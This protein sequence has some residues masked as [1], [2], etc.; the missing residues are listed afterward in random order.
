[1]A[2]KRLTDPGFLDGSFKSRSFLDALSSSSSNANFPDLKPSSFRGLPSLWISEEEI[3]AL[4]TP[5]QFLLVG[6]FFPSRRPSL[7]VI[8]R[9]F[10]NLKLIGNISVTLLDTSHDLIKLINNLDYSRIFYHISYLDLDNGQLIHRAIPSLPHSPPTNEGVDNVEFCGDTNKL[11]SI[12]P[13]GDPVD[14]EAKAADLSLTI[15]D[16]TK[17]DANL[18]AS[19]CVEAVTDVGDKS[20]SLV[21][22]GDGAG[23]LSASPG[24]LGIGFDALKA[25][26]AVNL[27]SSGVDH[28]DWLDN[29]SSPCGGD[30]EDVDVEVE[31][32]GVYNLN[33]SRI[34]EKTFS[35]GGGKRRD[36]WSVLSSCYWAR[37]W[38]MMR[39]SSALTQFG[40]GCWKPWWF[41]SDWWFTYVSGLMQFSVVLLWLLCDL[42][43]LMDGPFLAAGWMQDLFS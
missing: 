43:R 38:T 36:S 23:V 29:F 33:V 41:N 22:G 17:G 20:I 3:T 7:D 1:M 34:V 30:G 6:F 37:F 11:D 14:V 13:L 10:F 5:F 35:L 4:A 9:F 19:P 15:A 32:L 26:L 31:E 16:D 24:V 28:N 21:A 25:H 2:G 12:V 42:L 18:I 39:R 27:D 8:R 40:L